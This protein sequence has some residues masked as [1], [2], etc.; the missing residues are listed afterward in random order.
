MHQLR[1][2]RGAGAALGEGY[3]VIQL[4]ILRQADQA[5]TQRALQAAQCGIWYYH[6]ESDTR[7]ESVFSWRLGAGVLGYIYT[8]RAVRHMLVAWLGCTSIAT[9]MKCL[10]L[11]AMGMKHEVVCQ[12][13]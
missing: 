3:L 1:I 13:T 9:P 11:G 2:V 10:T 5:I 6:V 4:G 7:K 12:P 8:C